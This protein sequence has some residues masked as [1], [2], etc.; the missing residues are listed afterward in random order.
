M[1]ERH[2]DGG[3]A[4]H[5]NDG[6]DELQLGAGDDG[7][8]HQEHRDHQDDHRDD[9]WNLSRDQELILTNFR[10]DFH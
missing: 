8:D 7:S 1:H 5:E 4:A 2:I 3:T 6:V 10:I 9:D